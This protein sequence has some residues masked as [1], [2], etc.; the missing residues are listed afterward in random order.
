MSTII[1]PE[2]DRYR[3]CLV[4]AHQMIL[5]GEEPSWFRDYYYYT[6]ENGE[7]AGHLDQIAARCGVAAEIL[8]VYVLALHCSYQTGKTRKARKAREIKRSL[9]SVRKL[10]KKAADELASLRDEVSP[11]R[12]GVKEHFGSPR[13]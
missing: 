1:L 7:E 5:A 11:E 9:V 2:W 10:L 6:C 12:L 13:D 8:A 3:K 4:Q